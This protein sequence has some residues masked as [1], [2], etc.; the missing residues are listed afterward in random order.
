M[1][2]EMITDKKK[3]RE[4]LTQLQS[5]MWEKVESIKEQS[6]QLTAMEKVAHQ[7]KHALKKPEEGDANG[8]S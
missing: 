2:E 7:I 1:T 4:K 3:L 8:K 5:D 6:L